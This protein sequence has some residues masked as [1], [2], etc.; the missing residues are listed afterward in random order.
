VKTF[1]ISLIQSKQ[2]ELLKYIAL[3]LMTLDHFGKYF[4]TCNEGFCITT[5][6]GRI[7]FP[8]FAYLLM[9][10]YIYHSK[11]QR[12]YVIKLLFFSLIA[13][14]P[15]ALLFHPL[16]STGEMNILFSLGTGLGVVYILDTLKEKFKKKVAQYLL[17]FITIYI[18][19]VITELLDSSML[20]PLTVWSFY[21]YIKNPILLNLVGLVA[22]ILLLN[23][24]T[25]PYYVASSLMSLLLIYFFNK[26]N[27]GVHRR[28]AGIFF[29]I[30]YPLH[31]VA[32]LLIGSYV[33]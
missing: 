22:S 21:L 17:G 4:F 14:Y 11:H 6:L 16:D 32:I 33:Y 26:T 29:Y 31:L 10:N 18:A 1:S 23:F 5:L 3:F 20:L 19:F 15:Y 7:V 8:I 25:Q 30:Y 12:A 13:Q 2:Q 24:E 28:V 27:I 9:F